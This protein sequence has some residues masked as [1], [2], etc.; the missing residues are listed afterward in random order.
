M[1]IAEE[2]M[3]RRQPLSF[4][5]LTPQEISAKFS[6]ILQLDRKKYIQDHVDAYEKEQV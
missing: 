3:R 2:E 4:R 1:Y 6:A 5:N